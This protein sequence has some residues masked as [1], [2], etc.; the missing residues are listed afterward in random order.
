ME[1]QKRLLNQTS[2]TSG[3]AGGAGTSETEFISLQGQILFQNPHE[4]MDDE[5]D[6]DDTRVGSDVSAIGEY[7]MS[8]MSRNASSTSLRSRSTTGGSGPP[9]SQLPSRI[10]PPRFPM[11]DYVHGMNGPP[12]T[13]S[14]NMSNPGTPADERGPMSYFSPTAGSPVSMR[15]SSQAG[16]YPFPRQQVSMPNGWTTDENKHNT[17]PPISRLAKNHTL[18]NAYIIDGRTVQR[19]SLPPMTPSQSAQQLAFTQSRLRSASSPDIQNASNPG[20]KRYPN[21]QIQPS[22]E[23][24]PIPPIPAHMVSIHAPINRSQSGS[25][26]DIQ[27]RN[28]AQ[29]PKSSRERPNLQQYPSHY[30]YDQSQ[31]TYSRSDPRHYSGQSGTSFTPSMSSMGERIMSSPLQ[32]SATTNDQAPYPSQLKVK[33]WFEPRPSHVTIVVPII[34]KHRSLIDRIDSKM[35][36][37]TSSSIAKGTARL[38]YHDSDDELVTMACDEDVQIAI[39][40]WVTVNE[41]S[42]RSGVIPDFELHWHEIGQ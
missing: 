19:P 31:Q 10:P 21:G 29:S 11:P 40:E 20:Q 23:A 1:K 4:Q 37:V 6:D 13:I 16:M 17:A 39:E 33:I 42:L 5:E 7:T 12:L 35:E 36:K 41:L 2:R 14:T 24:V 15:S 8:S 22:S 38:R 25:P 30:S 32:A 18:N 26:T 9:M 34:I 27:R 28:P 3:Q